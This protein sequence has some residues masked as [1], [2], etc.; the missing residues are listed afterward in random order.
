MRRRIIQRTDPTQPFSPPHQ[1]MQAPQMR[2]SPSWPAAPEQPPL[3]A[4]PTTTAYPPA[5]SS[6]NLWGSGITP[7]PAPASLPFGLAHQGPEN[8]APP[9]A[10]F[11]PMFRLATALSS[12]AGTVPIILP[13]H[14]EFIGEPLTEW[15]PP[16]KNSTLLPAIIFLGLIIGACLWVLRDD[17]F[18]PLIAEIPAPIAAAPTMAR[19]A[20]IITPKTPDKPVPEIR[21]AELPLMPSVNLVAAGEA[22]LPLFQA[23]LDAKTPAERAAL[24][25]QPEDYAADLEGFFAITKPKLISLKPSSVTPHLLPGQ[26]AVPLFQIK[27]ES[28][29]SGALLRLV[30]TANDS[31]LLDW[32]LFAET[33]QQKLAQFFKTKPTEPA[34][35]HVGLLRSHGMELPENQRSIQFAVTLQGSAD[36]SVTCM[37]VTQKNTPLGRF[38]DRET[39]WST[40]YIARL[41]LQHRK[42]EGGMPAVVILDCEGAAISSVR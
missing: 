8:M 2:D 30:P 23:L 34:W 1:A 32:P 7:H 31:L 19:P 4:P 11:S 36:N 42:L 22:A 12:A 9:Q 29:P 3:F 14:S 37:A 39:E 17:L 41:L 13:A 15:R 38:L 21:R 6:D 28:N 18:P 35:F 24:I 25:A 27:T 5:P 10:E 33:H 26:Q 20:P 16:A 40:V